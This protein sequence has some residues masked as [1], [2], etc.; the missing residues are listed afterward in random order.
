MGGLWD[1]TAMNSKDFSVVPLETLLRLRTKAR[2]F[3][4]DSNFRARFSLAISTLPFFATT[5]LTLAIVN[6]FHIW[7]F[8]SFF[9]SKTETTI[10]GSVQL[11]NLFFPVCQKILIDPCRMT[12]RNAFGCNTTKTDCPCLTHKHLIIPRGIRVLE[13][14]IFLTVT[15]FQ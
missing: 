6:S 4:L 14:T 2:A 13:G 3:A 1:Y 10:T 9:P 11:V 12:E 7:Y 5:H 8:V 15:G